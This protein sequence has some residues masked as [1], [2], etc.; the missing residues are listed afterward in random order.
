MTAR[1]VAF[2]IAAVAVVVVGALG[3]RRVTQIRAAEADAKPSTHIRRV[4]FVVVDEAKPEIEI[5]LPASARAAQ[6]TVLYPRASGTV[7]GL[8]VRIG[9]TVKRGQLLATI[10]APDVDAQARLAR[11]RVAEATVGL[12]LAKRNLAR[13]ER[14]ERE[15]LGT[16]QTTEDAQQ[17]H[18][19]AVAALAAGQAEVARVSA[20]VRYEKLL[21]PFDG[22]VSRRM[23]DNGASVVAGATPLLEIAE[24]G[25]LRVE[26][27]VPQ[28][29]ASVVRAGARVK[30]SPR[31][32]GASV[33]GTVV[34]TAGALDPVT[35]TLRVEVELP[36]QPDVLA[37]A[38]VNARIF[39]TRADRPALVPAMALAPIGADVRLAVL[40]PSNAVTWKKIDVI[41]DLGRDVEVSGDVAKGA[42]VVIY[43]PADLAEGEVVEPLAR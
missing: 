24:D 17:R 43:P 8:G 40:S 34:R 9:A 13:A 22:V 41:R 11:G 36:K 39:A 7:S 26:V 21:A 25:P 31:G 42:R 3:A 32:V 28:A 38:Y 4:R 19:A 12:D 20:L 18:N 27:D 10:D 6:S 30:V 33:D 35:R 29:L 1:R 23:I 14:L 2:V 16:P 37:G 15:G 5:V